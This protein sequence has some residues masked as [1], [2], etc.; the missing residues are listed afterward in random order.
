[1]KQ[2]IAVLGATGRTGIWIVKEALNRSHAVNALVRPQSSLDIEHPD[3]TII[4]GVP[5]STK[6]LAQTMQGCEA[7]LSALNISRK[8]E[9]WPWSELSSSPTFLSEVAQQVVNVAKETH[10]KRCLIVSAWGTGET[11]A[12]IPGWFRWVIDTTKIGVTYRD[13]ERQEEI[14]EKSDLDWT[15][16]LPG[17]TNE[18]D[19][20]PVQVVLES[21]TAKPDKLTISRRMVAKFMLDA[22]ENQSYIQQKPII[23]YKDQS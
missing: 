20:K 14:W 21:K 17:L 1:M 10:L 15:V 12:D 9:W 7:V 3:L 16:V 4:K 6:D 23:S 5:T 11:K 22:L 13:H 8:T 18:T 2:K 19:D